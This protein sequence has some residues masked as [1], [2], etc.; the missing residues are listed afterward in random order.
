M[1]ECSPAGQHANADRARPVADWYFLG[2]AD[3]EMQTI[4]EL[5]RRHAPDR[6]SDRGLAWGAKASDYADELEQVRAAGY[7]PVLIELPW[8]LPQPLGDCVLVDHHGERAGADAA[9]SLEQVFQ[10]LGLPARD[11]TRWLALVAANDRGH[12]A[13]MQAAGASR[14]E[15]TAVRQADRAAQGVTAEQEAQAETAIATR[16]CL[17]EGALVEVNLPHGRVAPV[18]DR[19]DAA[20]GGPGFETLVVFSPDEVNV[21]GPGAVI[22]GLDRAFPGGWCGGNLPER[23]FWGCAGRALAADAVRA[24]L[25]RHYAA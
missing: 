8:D 4:A 20:L 22:V 10:R 11:W 21:F 2:G 16:R 17:A 23:G 3:L 9:T 19:L 12:I 13:A 5:L 18:A 6:F 25:H 24:W 7:R 1:V 14:E 15:I